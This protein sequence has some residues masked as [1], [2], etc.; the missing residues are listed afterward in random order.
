MNIVFQL[1]VVQTVRDLQLVLRGFFKQYGRGGLMLKSQLPDSNPIPLK[2]R[3]LCKPVT[4]KII[5]SR[6]NVL[7][8]VWCGSLE[9]GVPVQVS[10]LSSD[11]GSK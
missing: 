11:R 6:S 10:S 7:P 5:R 2:I 3:R 9:S 1:N 8:L 4:R